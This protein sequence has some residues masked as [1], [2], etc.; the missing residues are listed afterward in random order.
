M[1]LVYKSEKTITLIT[2]NSSNFFAITWDAMDDKNEKLASGVYIYVIQR[3]DEITKG[4]VVI[5]N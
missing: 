4:K 2:K 5:L 1:E 3:G